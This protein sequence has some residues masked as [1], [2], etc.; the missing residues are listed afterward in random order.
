MTS[1]CWWCWHWIHFLLRKSWKKN[2][3][4]KWI[5]ESTKE[6]YLY[7]RLVWV[8]LQMGVWKYQFQCWNFHA[9]SENLFYSYFWHR[10]CI[11]LCRFFFVSYEIRVK[12]RSILPSIIIYLVLTNFKWFSMCCMQLTMSSLDLNIFQLLIILSYHYCRYLTVKIE[13]FIISIILI[14][15]WNHFIFLVS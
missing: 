7:Y 6:F 4:W 5:F 10:T 9:D 14:L 12:A 11:F 15:T 1:Y 3:V 13:Y 2:Y 8:E